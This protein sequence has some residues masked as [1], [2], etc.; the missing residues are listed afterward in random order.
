MTITRLFFY[1]TLATCLLWGRAAWAHPTLD[2]VPASAAS[3]GQ[4]VTPAAK[5]PASHAQTHTSKTIKPAKSIKGTSSRQ[6]S[7]G[8]S[9]SLSHQPHQIDSYQNAVTP[10]PVATDR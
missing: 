3:A 10:P 1:A 4:S 9:Y 8:N 2:G 5:T 6:A 7:A